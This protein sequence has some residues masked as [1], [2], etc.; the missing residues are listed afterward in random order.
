MKTREEIE[1]DLQYLKPVLRDRFQ[2]ETIG[3]FGS[4]SRG[5]QK[6][7]SD[8]DILVTF[9]E[10]NDIDL[11][12]FIELK[13]FLSRKLKTKVDVVQKRALK[14]RIKDKILQETIYV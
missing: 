10:P 9:A 14:H 6:N 12:D 1:A 2:V 3:I 4:Y 13:Q 11:I 5:E 7:T 8:I